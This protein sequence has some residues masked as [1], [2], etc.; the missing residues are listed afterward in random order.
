MNPEHT[1]DRTEALDLVLFVSDL[2]E[3]DMAAALPALGLTKARTHV[4]W[5]L[6]GQDGCTQR[7]LADAVGVAPRTMTELVDV[8]VETGFVTREPHPDDRRAQRVCLTDKGRRTMTS[9]RESHVELAGTLFGP[10]SATRYHAFVGGLRELTTRLQ[11]AI[12]DAA[13]AGE[14]PGA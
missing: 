1:P 3:R 11:E 4:L 6:S 12:D 9:M 7:E 8:L 5:A 13:A 14:A 10:M 2:L